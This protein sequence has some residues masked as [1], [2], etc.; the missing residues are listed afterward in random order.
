[1]GE[2]AVQANTGADG[3]VPDNAESAADSRREEN[4]QKLQQDR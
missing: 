3:H 4:N 2:A 1:M